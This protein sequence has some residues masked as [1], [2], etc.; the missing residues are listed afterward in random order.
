MRIL[1]ANNFYYNRGGASTYTFLLVDLLKKNGN[2]VIPFAM[3]HPQNN[4]SEFSEYFVSYIDYTKEI[5][6][7]NL[8]SGIRVLPKCIF[9]YEAYKKILDI[10]FEK[11]PD[12]AHLHEIHHHITPSILYALKQHNVPIIWTLHDY[13]LICPNTH[14]LSHGEICERCKKHKYYWA[15]LTKC[16]KN[17]FFASALAALES[18][19]HKFMKISDL[20]DI[21]I[22]PSEFLRKKFIEYGYDG[23]KIINIPNPVNISA[24]LNENKDNGYFLYI[25]RLSPEKGVKTLIEATLLSGVGKLKIVGDGI[26][27]QELINYKRTKR[28][29]RLIEF[30]GHKRHEEVL[31]LIQ[32]SR[33]VVVPS[34]WY[35]NFPYSI[36]EA[37][38]YGKPVIGSSIGGIPELIKDGFNGFLFKPKDVNKLAEIIYRLN[39]YPDI[40]KKM[41]RNAHRICFN[42][43]NPEK[44]IKK[45]LREYEKIISKASA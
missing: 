3:K 18:S 1:L 20:V 30:L 15:P 16:K 7:I 37:F 5:K 26:L 23:E 13:V 9:S 35:E 33:F 41:G 45:V 32:N 40:A 39:K 8:F 34:E 4:I 22:S 25:G 43:Y 12:I 6:N 10:I 11:K 38:S 28:S 19:I 27:R 36:L 14:F 21:F 24:H 17:S 29:A 44:H 2:D 31:K 42:L